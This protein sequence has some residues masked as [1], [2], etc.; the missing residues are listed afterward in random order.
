VFFAPASSATGRLV[1]AHDHASVQLN[2]A[3]V[4]ANGRVT[5]ELK[6]YTLS[7]F[8]RASGEADDSLNRLLTE[9][10]YLKQYVLGGDLRG[11]L[12]LTRR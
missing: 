3:E 7:G 6:S 2:I 12:V 5:G 9:D 1:P 11:T 4:D 8:L 10:G